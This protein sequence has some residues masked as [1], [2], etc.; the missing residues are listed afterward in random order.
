MALTIP[1]LLVAL[2][3]VWESRHETEDLIHNIAVCLWVC[4]NMIWMTGEFYFNDGTRTPAKVF[5]F[6]GLAVLIA[7]YG[8]M[9]LR[10]LRG[11]QSAS[12]E[13]A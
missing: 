7:Y 2:K 12:P 3:I 10:R 5:F 8:T 11:S 13:T 9:G 1:T 4:A 6:T